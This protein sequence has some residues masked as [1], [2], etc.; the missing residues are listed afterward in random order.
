MAK[1][2]LSDI[3][4]LQNEVTAIGTMT[5]NNNAIEVAV[6]NTLSRDGTSP[7]EM[8]A[9]FDMNS[10]R[11][12]NLPAPV[13]DAEPARLID[14]VGLGDGADGADGE[15]GADG[16]PGAP[17]ATGPVA[18]LPP[19][20]W[21]T[22]TAY[23]VGPPASVVI[24]GGETYVCLISHTS[25]TF[26]TDL[27][28]VKW[29]KV[30]AKGSDGAGSGDMIG[31]NN[32]AAGA[33]GV[34]SAATA[35][36]NIKQAATTSATG[37]VEL[38]TDAETITGTDAVRAITPS[39][40]T[41]RVSSTTATGIVELSTDAE[42]IA[43]ADTVRTITPSNLAALG[44]SDTFAGFVELATP[45]EAV[46]GTDTSRAVTAAGLTAAM[47]LNGARLAK[48]A[49]YTVVNADK[50][51]TIAMAGSAYYTLTFGVASG[52]DANFM[53]LLVNEDTTAGKKISFN[54]LTSFILWPGQVVIGFVSNSVWKTTGPYR[55][56]LTGAQTFYVDV[57]NGNDAND[58]LA[59][60][61][62]RAVKTIQQALLNIQKLVDLNGNNPT[63]QL[64]AGTYPENFA[65]LG[66]FTGGPEVTILGDNTTPSNVVWKPAANATAFHA[67]DGAIVQITGVQFDGTNS[68]CTGI[69]SSQFAVVDLTNI[70]FTA[71]TSGIVMQSDDGG[72]INLVAG[73]FKFS[74]NFIYG[75]YINGGSFHVPAGITFNLPNALTFTQFVFAYR[76]SM[77]C[78]G[79]I[80]MTGTGAAGGSTGAKYSINFNATC[81]A[82]GTT[83]PGATAGGTGTGG[84]YV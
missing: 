77:S 47:V 14:I 32:L 72:K 24:Q 23:V 59:T 53:V 39:N 3:A 29:I 22:A 56:I 35:F 82:N 26:A 45:A 38:A 71:F 51:K 81:L 42:A 78:D 4:N 11:I 17:G 48:T 84:Q 57:T 62:G 64:A 8:N 43:K 1:I 44:A 10:H 41:A 73:T 25:G 9:D 76:G 66:A 34:A 63:V 58:G 69:E 7:N 65:L 21:L 67:R 37:V 68:G 31:A 20:A 33:G 5:S 27:A 83:F 19:V 15:D 79:A 30:A 74:G 61:T 28:A 50:G 2:T 49:A 52:F 36:S 70:W 60:G 54:G 6:E 18:W 55:W 40:L 13:N 80:T 75:I 12:L 16:A 46:T